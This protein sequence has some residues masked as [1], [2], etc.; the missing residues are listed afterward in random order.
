MILSPQDFGKAIRRALA[1]TQAGPGIL[2]TGGSSNDTV[3][4][5]SGFRRQPAFTAKISASTSLGNNQWTYT[6]AEVTKT[7][8]GYTEWTTRTGGRSGTAHNLFEDM[9]D[10]AGIQGNGINI[11]GADFP[12]GFAV[13]AV[14]TGTVVMVHRIVESGGDQEFWF[15]YVNAVDGECDAPALN[16]SVGFAAAKSGNETS[17]SST[18]ADVDSWAAATFMDTDAFG[19]AA[20]TGILTVQPGTYRIRLRVGATAATNNATSAIRLSQNTDSAGYA[21]FGPTLK[22]AAE[23]IAADA[24]IGDITAYHI[25][26]A[27]ETALLKIEFS[28][29]AGTGT[30]TLQAA[31]CL[32][33]VERVA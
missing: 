23:A 16:T 22:L 28:R 20:S 11:D 6:F 24:I 14:P 18:Y 4:L 10:G 2:V 21:T 19:F 17:T 30:A 27:S 3:S 31:E 9:N 15:S 29:S 13:Q 26:P 1:T 25:V 8:T 33:E 5:A 12:E 32:W 7:G